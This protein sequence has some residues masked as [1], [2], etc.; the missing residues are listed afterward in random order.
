ML[1]SQRQRGHTRALLTLLISRIYA[2]WEVSF[3]P[4]F[5]W[6]GVHAS[7]AMPGSALERGSS[8]VIEVLSLVL[9]PYFTCK[10]SHV[11]YLYIVS[12]FFSFIC[13]DNYRAGFSAPVPLTEVALRC[14]ICNMLK[15]FKGSI[16]VEICR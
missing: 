15:F 3:G 2:N 14:K 13:V 6:E 1:N 16:R 12:F 5:F 10:I 4:Y 11:N 9:C 8:F 7:L